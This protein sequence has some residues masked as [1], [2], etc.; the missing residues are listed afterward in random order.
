MQEKY[1]EQVNRNF[2][3]AAILLTNY[4]PN[5][6]ER[7]K[8]CQ[9]VT[10]FNFPIRRDD[11]SIANIDAWLAQHSTHKKPTKG[12]INMRWNVDED[13][14]QALGASMSFKCALVDVPFGGSKGTIRVERRNWS[15]HEIERMV[16][17]YTHE[18]IKRNLIGPDENVPGQDYGTS[19]QE[20]GWIVD[21]YQQEASDKRDP[22]ACVTGKPVSM[23]GLKERASATGRGLYF[24]LR[25]VCAHKSDMQKL[26]LET[27][28][29]GKR[30]VVQGL[31]KVGYW[32]AKFLAENGAIL[33]G[34]SEIEGA[35]KNEKGIDLEKAMEYR[36]EHNTF[37]N[38][39][40]VVNLSTP[41]DVFELECDVIVPAALENQI[42][43]TNV[44]KIKAPIILEAA[45]GPVSARA[46]DFLFKNGKLSIADIF[47]NAGGVIVSYF[48][49]LKNR[50]HIGFGAMDRRFEERQAKT[51][52][53]VVEF[54]TGK[55]V[56]PDR[57]KLIHAASEEDIIVSGLEDM[58]VV[59]YNAIRETQAKYND[60]IDFRTAAYLIA[61]EKI[62]RCYLD[63]GIWP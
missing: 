60:T 48:E 7:I 42:T 12:G 38:F 18:L 56:D 41:E 33:V 13:E 51:L 39:P 35:I 46:S 20:M 47:D 21:T 44:R 19:Q 31:G 57:R 30:F 2:D 61:I 24:A 3:K 8:K 43:M 11:G 22:S 28:V 58:M 27:G 45:N 37:L 5:L 52:V 49:W 53:D 14:V 4:E 9:S 50:S 1:L 17:R 10:H 36:R 59:A 32:A 26:G 15:I 54:A 55:T 6:L 29:E 63:H 40:D 16:R 34:L 62:A 23:G 25:E